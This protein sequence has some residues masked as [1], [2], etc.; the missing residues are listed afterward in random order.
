[1]NPLILI[2][3]ALAVNWKGVLPLVKQTARESGRSRLDI[4]SDMIRCYREDGYTWDNYVTFGFHLQRDP[5]MRATFLSQ[6]AMDRFSLVAHSPESREILRDKGKFLRHFVDFVKRDFVDLRVDSFEQWNAF[7]DKNEVFF[8]KP[9]LECGGKGVER[10]LS[11]EVTDRKALYQKLLDEQR[12]IVEEGIVQN[13]E[14]S[15]LSVNSINTLRVGSCRD[16]AGKISIPYVVLRLSLSKAFNDNATTGGGYVQVSETGII[17]NLPVTCSPLVEYYEKN[18]LTGFP[19]RGFQI[20]QFEEVKALVVAAHETLPE[21]RYIGWDVAISD[22][23]PVLVEGN[24]NPAADLFQQ[25]RQLPGPE[26]AKAK[27]EK[28]LGMKF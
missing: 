12:F 19:Y 27:L 3:K 10:M 25:F 28:A 24:E 2:R 11:S 1:M 8:V 13:S 6:T 15:R 21:S 7:L 9:P 20:P 22:K 16:E 14:M 17:E 5:A 23:G 26:G 4:L 18:P